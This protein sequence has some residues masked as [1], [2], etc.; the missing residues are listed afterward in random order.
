MEEQRNPFLKKYD[1]WT[2]QEDRLRKSIED[3]IKEHIPTGSMHEFKYKPQAFVL[4]RAKGGW[5]QTDAIFIDFLVNGNIP[6]DIESFLKQEK[7]CEQ[8]GYASVSVPK[9]VNAEKIHNHA[10]R[11]E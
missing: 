7:G 8:P 1:N 6:A 3:I 11:Q 10:C 5:G 4:G 2:Q 9:R